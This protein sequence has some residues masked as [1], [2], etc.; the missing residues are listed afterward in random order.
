M[1]RWTLVLCACALLWEG[2]CAKE[3]A[4]P[5]DALDGS[6]QTEIPR[7]EYLVWNALPDRYE[8]EDGYPAVPNYLSAWVVEVEGTPQVLER[9][10]DVW[11]AVDNVA[12]PSSLW[13]ASVEIT[14]EIKVLDHACVHAL[15][16][17]HARSAHRN[18]YLGDEQLRPCLT[19]RQPVPMLHVRNVDTGEAVVLPPSFEAW[20]LDGGPILFTEY[21]EHIDIV[22][23][24]GNTVF[25]TR[26]TAV[27]VRGSAHGSSACEA[28]LVDLD[29]QKLQTLDEWAGDW[30]ASDAF[31]ALRDQAH[32]KMRAQDDQSCAHE[33]PD[34]AED[35][36]LVA[37]WPVV[38]DDALRMTYRFL[39]N[40]S[41]VCGAYGWGSYT[42]AVDVHSPT[43]PPKVPEDHAQVPALVE[44]YMGRFDGGVA[45]GWRPIRGG[46]DVVR[47]FVYR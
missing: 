40:A 22:G 36:Y 17:K 8:P 18:T 38:F 25:A 27:E 2:C 12:G 46:T 30:L 39:A 33:F 45:R 26:C 29:A 42:L 4:T 16:E 3:A 37:L 21:A 5:A 9:R 47:Q 35:M 1:I 7:Q 14:S 41:Y 43:L 28:I 19:K 44:D 15:E 32:Q 34:T 13:R 24:A 20:D 31:Y 11:T 23:V 10:S 6:Q